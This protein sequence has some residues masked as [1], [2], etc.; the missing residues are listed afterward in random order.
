[1]AENEQGML[2]VD[3]HYTGI[4]QSI[5]SALYH[6]RASIKMLED[7]KDRLDIA[8]IKKGLIE[9]ERRIS[10]N[11]RRNNKRRL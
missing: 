5:N 2:G 11:D 9:K 7:I 8:A 1:M 10:N 3:L 6:H 4:A